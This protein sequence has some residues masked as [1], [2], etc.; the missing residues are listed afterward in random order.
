MHTTEED[1]LRWIFVIFSTV[2]FILFDLLYF[3]VVV[4]YASHS[5][6]IQYYIISIQEKVGEKT[7]KC[8]KDAI[9]VS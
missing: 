1:I 3:T 7:Y 2:G 5:Q 8:L 4:T 6:L 9:R